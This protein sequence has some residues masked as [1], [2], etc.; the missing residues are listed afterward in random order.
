MSFTRGALV[1]SALTL[2]A[3]LA[4]CGRSAS[5]NGAA[6]SASAP[7][8]SL[9]AAAPKACDVLTEATAKK[10]LGAD[11]QLRRNAQPNAHETQCQ[12]GSGKGIITVMVGPWDMVHMQ[13][14]NNTP[15]PG[16]G[17]EAYIGPGGLDVRKGERGVNIMVMT[18]AGEFCSKAAD[19]EEAKTAAAEEKV[20]PDI[21]AKL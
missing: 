10:Y 9:F 15:A 12:W 7:A 14:M 20:A 19:T 8:A 16:F 13:A 21:V 18:E 17:D 2:A 4:G 1:L 3:L 5:T 6:A 11:A